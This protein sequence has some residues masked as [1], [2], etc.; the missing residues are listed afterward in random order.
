M[1]LLRTSDEAAAATL[2]LLQGAPRTLE[3]LLTDPDYFGLTT[4]TPLQRAICRVADGLPLGD[5]STRDDVRSAIGGAPAGRPAEV[6]IISG[7]RTAKSLTTAAAGI[8][9]SQTCDV[10]RLGAGEIPRV[11]IVSLKLDLAGVIMQ[12]LLGNMLA[13]PKLRAL[14]LEHKADTVMVR[15]PTGRPVEIKV[16]AG[17]RAGASLV[18]R[19]SAGC[20]FDEAPRMVGQEDGVVNLDDMRAA[21]VG[22]LLPGAQIFTIGSPWAPFGPVYQMVLEHWRKPSA[23]LVVV[24][25]PAWH[26]NPIKW[27]PEECERLRVTDPTAYRTD[28][29]AEFADAEEALIPTVALEQCTRETPL[30]EPRQDGHS[31]VAAMDPATRS[32]AWTLV[33]ATRGEGKRRIV[34]ARQWQGSPVQPLDPRVVLAEIA[35]AVRAY[36]LAS[37]ETDQWSTDALRS[38]ARPLGLNL[39]EWPATA[40]DNAEMYLELRRRIESREVELPPDPIVRADLQRLRKRVTQT[41]V[42]V[43]L[44]KTSDGRHCDYA[45][46][47]ARVLRRFVSEPTAPPPVPGTPEHFAK[48]Q[49]RLLEQA[50]KRYGQKRGPWWKTGM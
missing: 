23:R 22:R 30:I 21:V 44:P 19:W 42:Q 38:I 36:G 26:M 31:Y 27:T 2:R 25:A 40:A 24:K 13:K 11:S 15:H 34:C 39:A 43:V 3:Q 48:E 4:A 35:E 14:L 37:V 16:V 12:H 9:M 45:P 18:A 17:A 47:L 49:A 7:I 41:G 5:L 6:C 33:I 10:S 8:R 29:E 1:G 20:I 46:P 32:N 50:K 28:C